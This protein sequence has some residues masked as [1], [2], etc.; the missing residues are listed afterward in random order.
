M[1]PPILQQE[2]QSQNSSPTTNQSFLLVASPI[3]AYTNWEKNSKS[4]EEYYYA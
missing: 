3:S 4:K 1:G 2:S